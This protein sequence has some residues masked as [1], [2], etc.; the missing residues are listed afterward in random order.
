MLTLILFLAL[1]NF[2][3][4]EAFYNSIFPFLLCLAAEAAVGKAA[5]VAAFS[6]SFLS[7]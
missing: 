3:F 7:I 1:S 2:F 5:N 6:P 4:L